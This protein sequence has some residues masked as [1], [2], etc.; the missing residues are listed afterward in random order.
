MPTASATGKIIL[1]GEYAVVFGYPGIAIPSTLGI[2]CTLEDGDDQVLWEGAPQEWLTYAWSIIT[3]SAKKK[4]GT[5]RIQ[6]TL[7]LSK[8]MGSS[9][10][11]VIALGRLLLGDDEETIRR[12]EDTVNPGHS[13][14]DFAVTWRGQPVIFRKGQTPQALGIDLSFLRHS[15]LI[16]TGTPSETTRELVAWM[17]SR[18]KSEIDAAL[19]T[20][21]EC[22][23][24]LASGESPFSVFPRHHRAQ[25]T[26]GVVPP[27]VQSLIENIERLGGTAK[28]IGAGARSGGAGMVLAIHENPDLMRESLPKGFSVISL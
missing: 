26:L 1:S 19:R 5:V 20:I 11:L 15:I 27:T 13:G 8:G 4:I 2:S 7:P 14:M 21:G 12:I 6:N 25:V 17:Q 9:T 10:A 23:E 16:D 28:V 18:P 22:T 24:R 3:L